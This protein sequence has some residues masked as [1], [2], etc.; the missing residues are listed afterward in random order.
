MLRPGRAGRQLKSFFW[1][2]STRDEVDADIAYHLDMLTRELMEKGLP[3]K[4][5]RAEAERRFGDVQAVTTESRRLAEERD[6]NTRR[7]EL[8]SELLQDVTFAI[9]QLRRA[10][11]FSAMA[12]LTLALGFGATAAVFSALYAVVL[13]PLPFHEAERVVTVRATRRGEMTGVSAAE[14]FSLQDKSKDAFEHLAAMVETGFTVRAGE[15][16]ELVE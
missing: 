14:F 6:H 13:K 10:P 12:V 16:P 7:A 5:A 11:V 15:T 9:R 8:R 2:A 4:Q 1:R 3:E